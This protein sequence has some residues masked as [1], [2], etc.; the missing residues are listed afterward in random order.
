MDHSH[1]A[2]VCT[3]GLAGDGLAGG[4]RPCQSHFSGLSTGLRW[5]IVGFTTTQL[6]LFVSLVGAGLIALLA[7]DP[8]IRRWSGWKWVIL[9]GVVS[10]LAWPPVA[11]INHYETYYFDQMY[12]MLGGGIVLNLGLLGLIFQGKTHPMRALS[13]LLF[14]EH[15]GHDGHGTNCECQSERGHCLTALFGRLPAA[16]LAVLGC[17]SAAHGSL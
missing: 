2:A 15:G 3:D 1:W 12:W 6:T 17:V 8:I 11:T 4:D 16:G 5:L 9:A 7:A 13:A 10:T 14:V